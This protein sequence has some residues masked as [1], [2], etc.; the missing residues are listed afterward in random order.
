M[1]KT[2]LSALFHT[3]FS[4]FLHPFKNQEE[5]RLLRENAEETSGTRHLR[6]ANSDIPTTD[7]LIEKQT[8]KPEEILSISWIFAAIE[9]LYGVLTIYLGNIFFQSWESSREMALLLPIDTTIYTQKALLTATLGKVT[10]F[11][12]IFW[13]WAGSWRILIQFFANLF[14]VEGD[15]YQ[16]SRQ[17]VQ[18]SMTSHVLLMIPIFGRMLRHLAGFVHIFAGLRENMRLSVLQSVIVI[19]SPAIIMTM[20]T[21]LFMVTML[22]LISLMF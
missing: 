12:L 16:M 17:I 19:V 7:E 3:Y 21:S 8:L 10:F 13:L 11:P 9:A 15:V 20:V 14:Q 5:L 4:N 22:Y 6:L 1:E 2:K 18:Q